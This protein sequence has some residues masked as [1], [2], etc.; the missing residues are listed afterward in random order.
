MFQSIPAFLV[1]LLRTQMFL[2]LVLIC[3]RAVK[4]DFTPL[5]EDFFNMCS[6]HGTTEGLNTTDNLSVQWL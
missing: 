5:L 4:N 3:I 6:V 2:I 1:L